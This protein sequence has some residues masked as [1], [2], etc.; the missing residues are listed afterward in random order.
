MPSKGFVDKYIFV[1]SL[2]FL[3][4]V[5]HSFMHLFINYSYEMILSICYS[6]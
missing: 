3:S 2:E 1:S 4:R 5:W 6:V